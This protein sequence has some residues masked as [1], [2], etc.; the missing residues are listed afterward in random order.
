MQ[1]PGQELRQLGDDHEHRDAILIGNPRLPC[2]RVVPD[3]LDLRRPVQAQQPG[4]N[5]RGAPSPSSP[6]RPQRLLGVPG[7]PVEQCWQH[8]RLPAR[9]LLPGCRLTVGSRISGRSAGESQGGHS[10]CSFREH[11]SRTGEVRHRCRQRGP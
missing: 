11:S 6:N 2:R 10:G 9:G 7:H 4:V 8:A 3:G 1:L 5:T